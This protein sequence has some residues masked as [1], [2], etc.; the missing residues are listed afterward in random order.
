[1]LLTSPIKE[2]YWFYQYIP[3][4]QF[5]YKK[6]TECAWMN[7]IPFTCYI[8]SIDIDKNTGQK[9][10]ILLFLNIFYTYHRCS[11]DTDSIKVN[12]IIHNVKHKIDN[13]STKK[14]S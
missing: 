9:E 1:M 7:K 3:L 11:P 12:N 13:D 5:V 2:T 6:N 14:Y 4:C 10:N 8:Y